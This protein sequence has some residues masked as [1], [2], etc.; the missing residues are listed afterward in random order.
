MT[1]VD[2]LDMSNQSLSTLGGVRRN[3]GKSRPMR[4]R[5]QLESNIAAS[6]YRARYL[7]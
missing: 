2:A 7:D 3:F 1:A 5:V 6:H 4:P